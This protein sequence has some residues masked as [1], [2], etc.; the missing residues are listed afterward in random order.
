MSEPLLVILGSCITMI[1]GAIVWVCKNKCRNQS[2]ECSSGC[3]KFHSDSRLRETIR[4][5]VRSE[6]RKSQSSNDSAS[7]DLEMGPEKATD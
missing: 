1:G 5:E 4:E 2:L 3:C 7:I 6:L